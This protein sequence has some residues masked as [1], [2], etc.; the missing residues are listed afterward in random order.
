MY[1]KPLIVVL[2]GVAFI[3]I[4]NFFMWGIIFIIGGI[5]YGLYLRTSNNLSDYVIT[6]KR[7]YAEG[8]DYFLNSK[9]SPIFF[10][11]VFFQL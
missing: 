5:L 7:I 11:L 2:I 10:A 9:I 8:G 4:I 6:N 1:I 3:I